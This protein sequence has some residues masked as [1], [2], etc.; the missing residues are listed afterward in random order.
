MTAIVCLPLKD[1]IL[2]PFD[3][4]TPE[5]MRHAYLPDAASGLFAPGWDVSRDNGHLAPYGLGSPFP[6]DSKLCAPLSSFWPAVAPDASR[7][8]SID[9][10][11]DQQ[12]VL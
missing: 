8:F 10:H 2:R 1:R 7:T 4:Q 12:L 5:T 11:L 3:V 9:T 6:E